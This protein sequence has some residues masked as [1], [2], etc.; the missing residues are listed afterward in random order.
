VK[1][2]LRILVVEDQLPLLNSYKL[3]LQH[4]GYHVAAAATFEEAREH[5][6]RSDCDVLMCDLG[7][8]G[9]GNGFDVIDYACR[10]HPYIH[11]LLITG[12]VGDE[13][14]Q[15]A[16]QRGIKVLHKPVGVA[17]LLHILTT[18]ESQ[19]AL[20]TPP[21]ASLE[22]KAKDPEFSSRAG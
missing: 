9:D 15:A 8:D 22:T 11:P 17:N 10:R 1:I 7:L 16:R 3:I 14:R 20:H 21:R 13:V 2:Q 18:I 6:D 5:L 12:F 19:L 4:Q